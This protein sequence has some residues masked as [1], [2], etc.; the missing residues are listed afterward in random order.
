MEHEGAEIFTLQGINSLFIFRGP[1]RHH[2]QAL[3]FTAGK[4]GRAMGSRQNTGL[5][6]NRTNIAGTAAIGSGFL[7]QNHIA[8]FMIF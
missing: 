8:D 4:Q 1:E 5:T 3:G 7:F 2:G 6:A